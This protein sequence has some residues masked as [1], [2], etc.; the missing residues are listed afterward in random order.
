MSKIFGFMVVMTIIMAACAPLPPSADPSTVII[1][2]QN[3]TP[4]SIATQEPSPSPEPTVIPCTPDDVRDDWWKLQ[5]LLEAKEVTLLEIGLAYSIWQVKSQQLCVGIGKD[6]MLFVTT[7]WT[8][9]KGL[10]NISS[11]DANIDDIGVAGKFRKEEKEFFENTYTRYFLEE[12]PIK[13]PNDSV[14]EAAWAGQKA[15][16]NADG[17][18]WFTGNVIPDIWDDDSPANKCFNMG[19]HEA[20]ATLPDNISF[21][22]FVTSRIEVLLI[23][24]FIEVYVLGG[25]ENDLGIVVFYDPPD[26]VFQGDIIVQYGRAGQL[27]AGQGLGGLIVKESCAKLKQDDYRRRFLLDPVLVSF[28]NGDGDELV[29][30]REAWIGVGTEDGK[31]YEKI[32]KVCP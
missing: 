22:R 2:T 32:Y 31:G 9:E 20:F 25:P 5:A 14:V 13:S 18:R 29:V 26:A 8:D 12:P 21:C 4:V 24:D 15:A 7:Y 11:H 28:A 17:R 19:F 6:D 1:A 30:P 23:A 27:F 3:P 16:I 10:T